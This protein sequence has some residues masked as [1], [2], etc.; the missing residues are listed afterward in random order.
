[1]VQGSAHDF[2]IERT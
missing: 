2:F 1:M